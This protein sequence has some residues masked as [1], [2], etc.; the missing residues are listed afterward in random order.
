MSNKFN[1]LFEAISKSC[2][3][4]NASELQGKTFEINEKEID[5]EFRLILDRMSVELIHNTF[6]NQ[7]LANALMKLSSIERIIIVFHIVLG[8][9]MIE[10]S[11]LLNISAENVYARKYR[12]LNLLRKYMNDDL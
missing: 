9:D 8:M 7:R 3:S 1:F 4:E 11:Y 5:Q 2:S 6:D 10:I 12:G